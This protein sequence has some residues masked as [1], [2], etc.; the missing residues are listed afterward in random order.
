[1]AVCFPYVWV[2]RTPF[3]QVVD[4][5]HIYAFGC[6]AELPR[7]FPDLI[8]FLFS[9]FLMLI[10]ISIFTMSII[11]GWLRFRAWGMATMDEVCEGK[12]P[13]DEQAKP[14][15]STDTEDSLCSLLTQDL[16]PQGETLKMPESKVLQDDLNS[17]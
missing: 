16:Q 8:V 12:A 2:I 9:F 7:N 5:T 4:S 17:L 6:I 15:S 3:L 10:A 14:D 11:W 13:S 1:M